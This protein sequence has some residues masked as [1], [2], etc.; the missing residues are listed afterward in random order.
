MLLRE[1]V[2]LEFQSP[3]IKIHEELGQ[4]PD[5][6]PKLGEEDEANEIRLVV[7]AKTDEDI[8]A[9]LN[10]GEHEKED[11]GSRERHENVLDV[12]AVV[13]MA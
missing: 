8:L 13:P 10:E 1:L 11:E 3:R 12:V 6:A 2:C 9:V 4:K 7:E 5:G